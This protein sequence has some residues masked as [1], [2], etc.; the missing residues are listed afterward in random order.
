MISVASAERPPRVQGCRAAPFKYPTP[1][2][3][4]SG[5][6]RVNDER[7]L[8]HGDKS[9]NSDRILAGEHFAR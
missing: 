6:N 4:S 5:T 1:F 7:P 3:F 2:G 8:R 9:V